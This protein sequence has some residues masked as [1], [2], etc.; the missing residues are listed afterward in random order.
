MSE[1]LK[2]LGL[3]QDVAKEITSTSDIL[4]YRNGSQDIVG[5]SGIRI[6]P[7]LSNS[8]EGGWRNT[9]YHTRRAKARS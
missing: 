8:I 5:L 4:G 6:Q 9:T 2:E 7:I 1:Y 3:S